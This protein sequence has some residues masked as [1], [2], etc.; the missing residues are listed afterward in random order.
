[1]ARAAPF[2]AKPRIAITISGGQEIES[3]V[4]NHDM[5][6]TGTPDDRGLAM[7]LPIRNFFNSPASAVVIFFSASGNQC[8]F[9][10]EEASTIFFCTGE[11]TCSARRVCVWAEVWVNNGKWSLGDHRIFAHIT[12]CGIRFGGQTHHLFCC[13]VIH[14][15][16]CLAPVEE[17]VRSNR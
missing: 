15:L 12:R 2:P 5:K 10:I 9:A 8:L 4:L 17:R 6:G 7:S 14:F 1:M 13:L 16:Y 11:V 3:A